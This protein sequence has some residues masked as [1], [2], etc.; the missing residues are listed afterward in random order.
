MVGTQ[1]IP[2]DQLFPWSTL[3]VFSRCEDTM[4]ISVPTGYCF[5]LCCLRS[6]LRS[7]LHM[8]KRSNQ[9]YLE[10]WEF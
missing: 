5:F 1:L 4:T 7:W 3:R 10:N 2:F 9:T 6:E 8:R